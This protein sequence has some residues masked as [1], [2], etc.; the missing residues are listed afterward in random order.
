MNYELIFLKFPDT[1]AQA[2]SA[3]KYH[4]IVHQS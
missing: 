3:H 2:L 1:R 4:F